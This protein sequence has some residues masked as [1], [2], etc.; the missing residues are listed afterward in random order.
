MKSGI[1]VQGEWCNIL[2]V[3]LGNGG[4]ASYPASKCISTIYEKKQLLNYDN[5]GSVNKD[6][7]K[8]ICESVP[9]LSDVEV[10]HIKGGVP[11]MDKDRNI[12]CYA[13]C[14]FTL[15]VDEPDMRTVSD[16]VIL[17]SDITSNEAAVK[18][19]ISSKMVEHDAYMKLVDGTHHTMSKDIKDLSSNIK[20]SVTEISDIKKEK[21]DF[22]RLMTIKQQLLFKESIS[23]DVTKLQDKISW[24]INELKTHHQTVMF[25]QLC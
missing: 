3:H 13:L 23:T 10:F 21:N 19:S 15:T 25:P 17:N 2:T 24:A 12:V 14:N 4:V 18:R 7:H 5:E 20:K 6:E 8:Y 1:S 9:A 11:Y 16:T 22:E